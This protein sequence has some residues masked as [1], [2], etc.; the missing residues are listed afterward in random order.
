MYKRYVAGSVRRS[1]AARRSLQSDPQPDRSEG[2]INLSGNRTAFMKRHVLSSAKTAAVLDEDAKYFLHQTLSSPCMNV[3][4]DC[5]GVYLRDAA[6]ARILDFHGNSVHQVGHKNPHVIA[7]I[8]RQ[9]DELPFS[10][11]RYTNT[12]AVAL[13]KKLVELAN[14]GEVEDES[15][16]L[17]R[18]LFCPGGTGAIGMAMKLARVAT[19]RHKTI[20]MWGS[21]HGASLDCVSIGGE[22]VFRKNIGPLLP[23]ANLVPPANEQRCSFNCG[24]DCN[25][26]CARYVAEVMENEGD[27]S[28]VIAEP[29]RCLPYVPKK[30]YWQLIRAACDKHGALLI[31][32]EIPNS[33]GRTGQSIFTHHLFSVTPDI[34]VLGKGLGGGIFPLAAMVAKEKYNAAA[35]SHAL[36]HY[37]HEKS[38][39]GCAAG[40]AT[41]EYIESH[42]L[43][44]NARII[45][46]HAVAELSGWVSRKHKY[47][48]S[49][50]GVGL[51]VGVELSVPGSGEKAVDEAEKVLYRCLELGLSFKVTAGCILTLCPPLTITKEQMDTAIGIIDQALTDF[52]L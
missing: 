11:R 9:L 25:L 23:G 47:V 12:T 16:R 4:E 27:I 18:V 3:V 20:S 21:F 36:G 32:D 24:G 48:S 29:I 31:F 17:S 8:K 34:L 2:D 49:V 5:D 38:P 46:D 51:L 45:G 52:G 50:R 42:G 14:P 40:L 1:L 37:T 28:A 35:Q 41:L 22:A 7:A 39:V 33:L 6:G 13:A 30:E 44:E 43:I 26:S 15:E 10:P 19:G